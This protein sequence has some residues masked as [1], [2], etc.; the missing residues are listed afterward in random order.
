MMHLG[1]SPYGRMYVGGIVYFYTFRGSQKENQFHK[2]V[3]KLM[4][5]IFILFV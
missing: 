2:W 3:S 1:A 4:F 5:D